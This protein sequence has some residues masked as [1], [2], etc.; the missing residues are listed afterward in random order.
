[1][2]TT[3]L[4]FAALKEFN[5]VH[6]L[7]VHFP[8][9]LLPASLLMYFLGTA[10]RKPAFNAAGR[11]CLYMGAAGGVL[12]VITGFQAE[13]SFP[14]GEAVHRLMETH[15]AVGL[16]VLGL[17]SVA[18]VWSFFHSEQRPRYAWPFLA[19]LGLSVLG[20]MQAADLGGR[21]V[22]LHGAAVKPVIEARQEKAPPA[23]AGSGE[24]GHSHDDGDHAH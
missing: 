2:D 1:M 12:A 11:A 5:N 4:G 21:M 20:V 23:E 13:G 7:F 3:L 22:Y 19:L 24:E 6:P 16:A 9:A 10:L 18:C 17:A 14:H 15:E 8:I